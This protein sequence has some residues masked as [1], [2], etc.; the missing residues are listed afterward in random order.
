[1]DKIDI[2]INNAG[3]MAIPD[4]RVTTDGY[5]MQMGINHFGHFYL[6]SLLWDKLRRSEAFRVINVS[7]G[8]H[9]GL[10]FPKYDLKIDF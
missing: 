5:E 10:G 9:K 6:T 7:S 2:L 8:A 4:R 3:V 1:V